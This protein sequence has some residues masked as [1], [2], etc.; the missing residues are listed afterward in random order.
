MNTKIKELFPIVIMG[1][2]CLSVWVYPAMLSGTN[3]WIV[4]AV[5]IFGLLFSV[6]LG[7]YIFKVVSGRLSKVSRLF[8][9]GMV[10]ML[11]PMILEL[12]LS[13]NSAIDIQFHDTYYVI[14]F[15]YI[16]F[17]FILIF[18]I[19]VILYYVIPFILK[20]NLYENLG[21]LHFWI[22]FLCIISLLLYLHFV[23]ASGSQR[24]YYSLYNTNISG[25]FQQTSK[26][27]GVHIAII[28]ATQLLFVLNVIFSFLN[29]SK[30]R[31]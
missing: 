16:L 22:S 13:M 17:F 10:M 25:L 8:M 14:A 3:P 6:V 31:Q 30:I 29:G 4:Q 19:W 15:L 9:L 1:V 11:M 24:S 12:F 28:S 18:G 23:C 7:R 26:T 27:I 5:L 21:L 20:K 2:L